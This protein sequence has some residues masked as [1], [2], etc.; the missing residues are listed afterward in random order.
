MVGDSSHENVQRGDGRGID[1]IPKLESLWYI[2]RS[3]L[4][5]QDCVIPN[6]SSTRTLINSCMCISGLLQIKGQY[7]KASQGRIQLAR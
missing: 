1:S 3:I 6:T 5:C 4:D 2:H 7:L